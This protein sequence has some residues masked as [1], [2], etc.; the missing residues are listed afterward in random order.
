MQSANYNDYGNQTP[1]SARSSKSVSSAQKGVLFSNE[2]YHND[3]HEA[4]IQYYHGQIA[5]L[6]EK[7][8]KVNNEKDEMTSMLHSLREEINTNSNNINT[9]SNNINKNNWEEEKQQ[10]LITIEELNESTTKI[11]QNLILEE[12]KVSIISLNLTKKN[13]IIAEQNKD[14]INYNDKFKEMELLNVEITNSISENQANWDDEKSNLIRNIEHLNSSLAIVSNSNSLINEQLSIDNRINE[15]N[16]N[17]ID[18]IEELNNKIKERDN[19]VIDLKE[20]VDDLNNELTDNIDEIKNMKLEKQKQEE[21]Q[22][23]PSFDELADN[24]LQVMLKNIMIERDNLLEENNRLANII[25]DKDEEII[26]KD[27]EIILSDEVINEFQAQLEETKKQMS[28]KLAEKSRIEKSL[29]SS[30]LD[31]SMDISGIISDNNAENVEIKELNLL[32]KQKDS[33][34]SQQVI[35]FETLQDSLSEIKE[36]NFVLNQQK[37]GLKELVDNLTIKVENNQDNNDKKENNIANELDLRSDLINMTNERD[38][39]LLNLDHIETRLALKTETSDELEQELDR[40]KNEVDSRIVDMQSLS[41]SNDSQM[42][43]TDIKL[44]NTDKEIDNLKELVQLLEV[45]GVEIDHS[46]QEKDNEL[47]HIESELFIERD[48]TTN[49]RG[50]LSKVKRYFIHLY[51]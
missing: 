28:N 20:V 14:L 50:L 42:N 21:N 1:G 12:E 15:N 19:E 5:L 34:L 25:C 46:L 30:R 4:D 49:L 39:L 31:Q 41:G 9:D 23:I 38:E 18:E 6:N 11:Q 7:L 37:I 35:Q 44:T 43:E 51:F 17:Y 29:N 22:D 13:N 8:E 27:E 24:K 33:Q 45:K 3:T 40:L 2:E 32:I 47:Q 36:N 48:L 10:L 26:A 16:I